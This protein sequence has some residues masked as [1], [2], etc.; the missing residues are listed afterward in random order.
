M[1][2]PLLALLSAPASAEVWV[3]RP[4]SLPL[5]IATPSETRGP[6]SAQDIREALERALSRSVA[7]DLRQIDAE[8]LRTCAGSVACVLGHKEMA[9]ARE[10][11][12]P[13][14]AGH[15]ALWLTA[16]ATEHSVSISGFLFDLGRADAAL[17]AGNAKDGDL[18]E[19]ATEFITSPEVLRDAVELSGYV[20][21]LATEQLRPVL[22]KQG[23]GHPLGDIRID[24]LS[25][26]AEVRVNGAAVGE[27]I[28][29]S[30]RIR[31]L[32]YGEAT[33]ELVP[34]QLEGTRT[35]VSI[36]S[37]VATVAADFRVPPPATA[38][39]LTG[40]G[41]AALLVA[42]ASLAIAGSVAVATHERV[43]CVGGVASDCY[44]IPITVPIGIGL[45]TAGIGTLAG[46][47][48]FG[49]WNDWPWPAWVLGIALGTGATVIAGV[50][51]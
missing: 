35:T 22:E 43:T 25:A 44:L 40:W 36:S 24:N 1:I 42:G 20:D 14:K 9:Q 50:A 34:F 41:G 19:N 21:R 46:E 39:T 5:V 51:R 13:A 7:A 10:E 28:E 48:T 32:P 4:L 31:G 8:V 17:K 15:H 3:E 33:I 18:I 16:V 27:L 47:L 12:F 23:S 37:E 45:G 11:K 29:G 26:A 38:R 30:G 2:I 49:E 6:I